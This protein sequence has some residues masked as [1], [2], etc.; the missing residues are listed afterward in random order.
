[1]RW[2]A[3]ARRSLWELL[4]RMGWLALVA[5][6][7][8][9]PVLAA[10]YLYRSWTL[11]DEG[12]VARGVVIDGVAGVTPGDAYYC[13][14][15]ISFEDHHGKPR[16]ARRNCADRPEIGEK[17]T[18]RY[19]A[20]NPAESY[21]DGDNQFI[22]LVVWLTAIG[23]WQLGKLFWRLLASE[24]E[25]SPPPGSSTGRSAPVVREPVWNSSAAEEL[26]RLGPAYPHP[27]SS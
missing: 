24:D 23:L 2:V 20:S 12:L 1:M 16:Q 5:L 19:S 17:V 9:G 21:V 27:R 8:L 10:T 13:V 3:A 15:T 14:E 11:I 7:L 25:S 6:F 4:P 26:R 22:G 18:V